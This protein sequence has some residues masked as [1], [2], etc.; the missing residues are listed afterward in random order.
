MRERSEVRNAIIDQYG[1]VLP[2]IQRKLAFEQAK[3]YHLSTSPVLQEGK[4]SLK[5]IKVSGEKGYQMIENLYKLKKVMNV[6][7]GIV[8]QVLG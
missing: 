4:I 5:T 8:H 6:Q 2:K 7:L 3:P 1:K